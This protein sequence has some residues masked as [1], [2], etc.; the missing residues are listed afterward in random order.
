MIDEQE[1]CLIGGVAVRVTVLDHALAAIHAMID[2]DARYGGENRRVVAF[3]NAHTVNLARRDSA[4]LAVLN[5]SFVLND[6]V[7]LDLARR[8]LHGAAFPAN[9]HGTDLTTAVLATAERPL[10]LFLLGSPPGVAE[11]AAAVLEIRFP[12]HRVV[13]THDGFFDE[14]EGAAIARTIAKTGADLV[15][16]GMGQPRQ[17]M[18]AFR[19]GAASGALVMCIGAYLDFTA[20]MVRRA[21]RWVQRVR[22]EW[23]VRLAQEPRRLAGRYLIGNARFVVGIAR[24]RM[25]ARKKF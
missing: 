14:A 4:F 22:L 25:R 17:E 12:H 24:D 10:R 2:G 1:R 19:H 23:F 15:L 21:P 13:G 9:L 16:V 7:G 11:C 3:C 6:G 8:W 20:G 18:W 5:D